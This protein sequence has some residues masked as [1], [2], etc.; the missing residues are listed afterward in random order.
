MRLVTLDLDG[1]LIR[2]T[3]FEAAADGLGLGDAVRRIDARYFAGE[4]SLEETFWQEHALFEGQPLAD[5]HA[6]L[7]EGPWVAHIPETVDALRARGLSVWLV[8]DQPSWAVSFLQR[9]GLREG[10]WSRAPVENHR[11]GPVVEAAFDK[12]AALST[13]LSEAGIDPGEVCHVGNGSN[14]VAIFER[15]GYAIAFNPDDEHVAGAADVVIEG[16]DLA[17]VVDHV[18]T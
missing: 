9:W 7:A 8:T 13:K 16:D 5:A 11:I 1:T 3:A 6:G 17:A 15:V 14:D 10:V 2:T 12:W 18:P 4:L